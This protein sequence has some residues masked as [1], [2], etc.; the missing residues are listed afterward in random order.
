MC[1]MPR[2]PPSEPPRAALTRLPK[3]AL[4]ARR[5]QP[6]MAAMR[7]CACGPAA[8]DAQWHTRMR[9]LSA[10]T[11]SCRRG[12]ACPFA[13]GVF[14]VSE[15]DA[16]C[17][18]RLGLQRSG[19]GVQRLYRGAAPR[20]THVALRCLLRE[21][22]AGTTRAT[23]PSATP[24]VCCRPHCAVLAAPI[25][26]QDPALHGRWLL[27][28]ARVSA[29]SD[30]GHSARCMALRRRRA[31]VGWHLSLM[32]PPRPADWAPHAPCGFCT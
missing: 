32:R 29:A 26:L 11:G 8:A 3:Q 7:A 15:G 6:C 30:M 10:Q 5:A 24:H 22:A 27:Q 16:A 12:D 17:A 31:T 21:H 28:A 14:E 20:R 4:C 9:P 25:A 23:H 2:V 13:H 1:S 19:R 18:P